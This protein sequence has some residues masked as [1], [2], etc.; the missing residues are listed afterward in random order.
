MTPLQAKD[1]WLIAS[2]EKGLERTAIDPNFAVFAGREKLKF[3]T[4]RH[5]HPVLYKIEL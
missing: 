5:D 1:D 4:I 2:V 3:D